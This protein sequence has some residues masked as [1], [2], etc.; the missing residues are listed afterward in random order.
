M[1]IDVP[2]D[3]LCEVAGDF[4]SYGQWTLYSINNRP[5][6]GRFTILL[7]A[8]DYERTAD[9]NH[10][11]FNVKYDLDV[12]WPF[13]RTDQ[14]IPFVIHKAVKRPEGGVD[15]LE[16]V[17]GNDSLLLDTFK[18]I[19][20]ASGDAK[21]SVIRFKSEVA[22]ASLVNPFFNLAGFRKNIEWRIVRVLKNLKRRL[23]P[24]MPPNAANE[25]GVKTERDARPSGGIKDSPP[26][27]SPRSNRFGPESKMRPVS[28]P[29]SP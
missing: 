3:R 26:P 9:S 11:V 25:F 18:V 2:L 20:L 21:K 1:Q 27:L 29:Q 14:V 7:K 23:Q 22:F 28:A 12:I 4:V 13:G 24:S 5:E 10:G 6:G 15:H 8:V 16:I 17:L 19:L